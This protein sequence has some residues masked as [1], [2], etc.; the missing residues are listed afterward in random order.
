MRVSICLLFLPLLLV[1]EKL[2]VKL[3]TK[4]L[5][6][7]VFLSGSGEKKEI[8]EEIKEVL[9]FDLK[10]SGVCTVSSKRANHTF[11]LQIEAS[12]NKFNATVFDAQKEKKREYKNIPFK[13]NKI[14]ELA[15]AFQRDL[16][17]QEGIASCKIIY[18][19]RTKNRTTSELEFLSEVWIADSDGKR[20]RRLT[21]DQN[22]CLSPQSFP[23][24]TDAFLYASEKTGQTKIYKSHLQNPK[25]EILVRLR[26][27]QELPAISKDARQIAFISDVAGRPDLFVQNLKDGRAVG[28]PRQLFSMQRAT[29]ASPT[30]S[31]DGKQ[32]AFVSDKDGP[33]RI[34]VIDASSKKNRARLL[35]RKNRENTSPSWSNDGKKLA[36]S[37]K[38][39]GVRQIWIYDFITGEE[40]AL[41][42]G[43]QNKENPSWAPNSLH[44]VYNTEKGELYTIHLNK[45]EPILLKKSGK[46]KR[47]ASWIPKS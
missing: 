9:E 15:D 46:Q 17:D 6:P 10:A 13:R 41:T 28:K 8:S 36:Y 19:E 37:A 25:A 29:Q 47:F 45:K 26:G 32:I 21:N 12:K 3:S 38:V 39:N 5:L 2:E 35:T 22:Y 30:Y 44:L 20:A 24:M 27:N 23:G 7:S 33:P 4:N 14:H 31:P 43:G 16:F 40:T 42:Q 11:Y 1:A 34:Y 18:T